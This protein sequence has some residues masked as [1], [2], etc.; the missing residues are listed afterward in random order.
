MKSFY[1]ILINF[2]GKMRRYRLTNQLYIILYKIGVVGFGQHLFAFLFRNNP[3]HPSQKM[4]NEKQF[5]SE[6]TQELK[7]VYDSLE[8]DRSRF[9]FEN[10]L[11]FRVTRE[12]SFIEKSRGEDN[13][14]TQYL[15]PELQF[16]DHEIIVDCGAFIGDTAE[17]FYKNI[18]G[19]RVI[20]LEPDEKV[21]ELLQQC[22]LEGLKAIKAGAWSEDTTLKFSDVGGGSS[23]ID[24]SGN[25][26]I[27]VVA[28]DH[29]SECQSATYI[30]MDIEG[31]EL[32]ALKGAENIIKS[33]KPKLAI[34]IY[35]KP[36]DF[37]E[38]PL[39]IKKLHPDYRLFIH[40][41]TDDVS[42]TVLYAV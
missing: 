20:A 23:T 15:A 6:H 10:V 37:F 21:F 42:E 4:N 13:K 2:A 27:K 28:L 29:L 35:H 11:H 17:K 5:F 18:L 32:E 26:E 31:A 7:A 1:S 39:Y 33:N 9:V 36:Q 22:G 41:H 12:Y 8:D 16:S 40:Q 34:C 3:T 14:S 25:T 24:I 38:I 30:K 19:C